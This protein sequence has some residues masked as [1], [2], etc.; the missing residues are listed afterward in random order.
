MTRAVPTIVVIVA[1]SVAAA[2]PFLWKIF[3]VWLE[4]NT[5]GKVT[6]K[7]KDGGDKEIA[8]EYSKLN[9]KEVEELVRIARERAKPAL[10]RIEFV[11]D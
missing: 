10:V 6:I 4:R 5:N 3:L 9:K 2:F 1:E 11:R 7:Y 8:I